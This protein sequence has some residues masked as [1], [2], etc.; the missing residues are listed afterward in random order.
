MSI[1]V[2]AETGRPLDA[3]TE[4]IP[5]WIC[6][7]GATTR[8]AGFCFNPHGRSVFG[9]R[10]SLLLGHRSMVDMLPRRASAWSQ[11]HLRGDTHSFLTGCWHVPGLQFLRAGRSVRGPAQSVETAV[12]Q[13]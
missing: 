3:T 9:S 5:K 8:M 1:T 7:G 12:T 2:E 11:I 13:V 10:P 6:K 4:H